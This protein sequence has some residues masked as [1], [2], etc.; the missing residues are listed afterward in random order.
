MQIPAR[1]RAVQ[2]WKPILE[3]RYD[4]YTPHPFKLPAIMVISFVKLLATYL[5]GR[6]LQYCYKS[7][8]E[9]QI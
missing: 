8:L 4:L 6:S 1:T 2:S 7:E 5:K 3:G 9:L